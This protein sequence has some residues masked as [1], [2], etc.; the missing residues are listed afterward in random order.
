[1][2]YPKYADWAQVQADVQSLYTLLALIALIGV[3]W[4]ILFRKRSELYSLL[5]VL[6]PG[7]FWGALVF[8]VLGGALGIW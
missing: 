2:E 3:S 4:L 8:T 5:R 7:L 1:M 6:L